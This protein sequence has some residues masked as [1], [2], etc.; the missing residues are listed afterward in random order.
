MRALSALP[1]RRYTYLFEEFLPRLRALGVGEGTIETLL[2]ANPRRYFAGE[3][4]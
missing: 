1:Q 4:L 2:V 3:P